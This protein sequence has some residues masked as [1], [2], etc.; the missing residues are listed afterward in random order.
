MN[1]SLAFIINSM[2]LG[3]ALAMDAFSVSIA[4]GLR[5][6]NVKGSLRFVIPFVFSFFQFLMPFLGWVFITFMTSVFEVLNKIIPYIAFITLLFLGIK[7]IADGI[8]EGKKAENSTTVITEAKL[9]FGI[10]LVQGIA[11]SIDAL[12][13]GLTLSGYDISST[14]ICCLIIA[15]VTYFICTLGILLGKSL[16]KKFSPYA[17]Y[18]GGIILILIGLEIL[19]TSF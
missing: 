18:I 19:I 5:Y 6:Q 7:M 12:S 16:G 2:L 17:P 14:L 4:D 8:R 1:L 13:V 11:T 3:I 10:L 15:V 9:S